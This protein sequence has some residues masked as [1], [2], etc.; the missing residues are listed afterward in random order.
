MSYGR[1][2][3]GTDG[4]RGILNETMDPVDVLR[5]SMSICTVLGEGSWILIGRDLRL[6]GEIL[7]LAV[8]A[9]LLNSGC[10]P[11]LAGLTPTPA[12]QLY[13]ARSGGFDAG[14]MITASH[15]PPQY[16]GVKLIMRD[17]IEAPREVEEEVEK[18]YFEERFRR[19][20]WREANVSVKR[21]EEVNS[22]YINEIVKLIDVGS[23]KRREPKVVIDAANSVGALTLPQ[24]A[25]RAG[26]RPFVLNGDLDPYMSGRDPEPTPESLRDASLTVVNLRADL[27]IG[28]DGDADRAIVIDERGEAYWGDRTALVLAPFLREKHPELPPR[29]FTG[30]ST[31]SFIEGLLTDLGITV[32]WLKVGSPII[33]RALSS[34][35]GL[36]GFEENGGL[37]YP[38]HQPVRDSGAVLALLLELLAV[39]KGSLSELYSLYPRTFSV[40]TKVPSHGI[41]LDRMYELLSSH[42]AR[43]R[44][45]RIDG[46]KIVTEDSWLLVRPSGTEP[47]VRI[48]AE[49]LTKERAEEL[50]NLARSLI[51]EA[52]IHRG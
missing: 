36:M 17:G 43:F 12:L 29:V 3:F 23:V 10:R 46:I 20:S 22:F 26:A 37:M 1:R 42:F 16:N 25:R 14:L 8:S 11:V 28:V 32:E 27:G 2:L 6:G 19:I 13:I 39:R 9:G 33:S 18:V 15:N 7:E 21:L 5:L 31:S 45:I 50:V 41:D 49:S 30:V 34:R 52:R 4:V 24:I 48:M 40:K 35:G 51:E 47:V 38:V 44:Q